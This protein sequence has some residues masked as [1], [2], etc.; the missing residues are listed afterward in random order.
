MTIRQTEDAMRS[1]IP[2]SGMI[3]ALILFLPGLAGHANAETVIRKIDP[4]YIA[5][6]GKPDA[7]S[8]TGAQEWGFWRVDPGP[9]GVRLT[10]FDALKAEG[11]RAPAGWKFDDAD[12]W[13]EE[14]GLIMEQPD[15]PLAPGRYVVTGGRQT[16][17]TLTIHPKDGKGDQ[18]WELDGGATIY[19]VTHL[20]CR[21]AR[22]RPAVE[23]QSCSPK[24]ALERRFPVELGAPMP[25]VDGCRKQD[26]EVLIVIGMVVDG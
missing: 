6:L 8:G 1:G 25:A 24:E 4:Q 3:L 5:A 7:S 2:G 26:Y 20:R 15:F 17:A 22:Y 23:G 19:D 18:A 12:W 14:H 16:T 13:L 10:S 21:A 9:R 11:N